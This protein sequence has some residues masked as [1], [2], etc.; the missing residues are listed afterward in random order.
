MAWKLH[1]EGKCKISSDLQVKK[2]RQ[3]TRNKYELIGSKEELE[4]LLS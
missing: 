3:N 2:E 4:R 1:Q